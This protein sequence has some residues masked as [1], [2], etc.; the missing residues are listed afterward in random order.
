MPIREGAEY[1]LL[2]RLRSHEPA[3]KCRDRGRSNETANRCRRPFL[4]TH[5]IEAGR[6]QESA[7]CWSGSL[8][9]H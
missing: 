9:Q 2:A 7:E 3:H 1:R 8:Y 5:E 4:G 6:Q